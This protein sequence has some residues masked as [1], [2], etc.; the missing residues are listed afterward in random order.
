MSDSQRPQK[1][2]RLDHDLI[3]DAARLLVPLPSWYEDFLFDGE[4]SGVE[5]IGLEA[6]DD[7]DDDDKD[8]L[9]RPYMAPKGAPSTSASMAVAGGSGT[10]VSTGSAQ[11]AATHAPLH[12]PD[13]QVKVT[14]ALK[15]KS[16]ER[17]SVEYQVDDHKYDVH[18]GV[19]C[20]SL[21]RAIV[22]REKN[23]R[24]GSSVSSIKYQIANSVLK[25]RLKEALQHAQVHPF[26]AKDL[27]AFIREVSEEYKEFFE[28]SAFSKL[29]SDLEADQSDVNPPVSINQSVIH[30]VL[31]ILC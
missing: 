24:V 28:D 23:L 15:H 18:V 22:Y 29:L 17:S 2:V 5:D 10:S 3:Q 8:F 14:Q 4:S 16:H 30:T 20:G 7:D 11:A 1:L 27:K 31:W 25:K 6:G 13:S 12:S 19:D 21:K 26:P 9:A